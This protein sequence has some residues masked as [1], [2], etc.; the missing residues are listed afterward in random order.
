MPE[1][2][3]KFRAVFAEWIG[4]QCRM[5]TLEFRIEEEKDALEV[6]EDIAPAGRD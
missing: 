4:P 6:A 3:K 5:V 2:L 1:D